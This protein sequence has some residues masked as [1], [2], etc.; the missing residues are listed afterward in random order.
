MLPILGTPKW[1]ESS[2][3]LLEIGM[4]VQSPH[5]RDEFTSAASQHDD[6]TNVTNFS[7]QLLHGRGKVGIYHLP[8]GPFVTTAGPPIEDQWI[9]LN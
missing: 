4:P 6:I 8:N 7:L 1:S 3:S 5:S 9:L 2:D